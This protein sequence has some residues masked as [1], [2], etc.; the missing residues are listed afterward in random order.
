MNMVYFS[1]VVA[2]AIKPLQGKTRDGIKITNSKE[3][4]LLI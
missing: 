4:M 2:I 3:V 1:A